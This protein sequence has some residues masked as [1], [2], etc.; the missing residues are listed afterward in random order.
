M[1]ERVLNAPV[2]L[3]FDTT[4]IG[5]I[6]NKFSKDLSAVESGFGW[7][8]GA[9]YYFIFS[10]LYTII[11]AVIAVPWVALVLPVIFLISW[12][13]LTNVKRAFKETTRLTSTTKSPLIS[14]LSETI[15]GS[16][17]IRAFGKVDQFIEGNKNF[18]NQNILAVVI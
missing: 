8:F 6:L 17:T 4:P 11:I 12:N 1:I 16:S 14:Y 15:T 9:V 10:L 3:Y 5:R 7:L 18:L 2:N 13:I